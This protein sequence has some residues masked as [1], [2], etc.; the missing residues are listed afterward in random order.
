V[1]VPVNRSENGATPAMSRSALSELQVGGMLAAVEVVG[2]GVIV[3]LPEPVGVG[4]MVPPG[5]DGVGDPVAP[6]APTV[7]LAGLVDCKT[8]SCG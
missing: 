8:F 6:V 7:T 3:A 1:P 5:T 2:I 4:I